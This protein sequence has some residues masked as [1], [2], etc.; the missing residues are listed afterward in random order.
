MTEFPRLSALLGSTDRVREEIER[1]VERAREHGDKALDAIG[2][3][4]G[5]WH[6]PADVV[7][8]GDEITVTIDIP[9]VT[10]E[11]VNVEVMGN[12]LTVTG[13]RDSDEPDSGSVVHAK[14]R[15]AGEFS[16]SIPMPVS[17]DADQVSA[18]IRN[19]VL[20][21]KLAKSETA[22]AHSIPITER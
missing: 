6:P 18:E 8:S 2:L 21:V 22:R 12:M 3:K 16:Q 1:L 15:P 14:N 19:G 11:Q 4:S 17:V 5:T 10:A 9:G 13:S 20:T 7:E